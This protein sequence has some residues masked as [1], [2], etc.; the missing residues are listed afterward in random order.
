ML[1]KMFFCFVSFSL[2]YA[3]QMMD[4]KNQCAIVIAFD[5]NA[6]PNLVCDFAFSA[7]GRRS[8][9]N[10]FLNASG[11]VHPEAAGIGINALA[12]M[13]QQFFPFCQPEGAGPAA[14]MAKCDNADDAVNAAISW[15]VSICAVVDVVFWGN[16]GVILG[17]IHGFTA[18]I[19]IV[20]DADAAEP[21]APV[22][23]KDGNVVRVGPNGTALDENEGVRIA[24]AVLHADDTKA[25]VRHGVGLA[26]GP[27]GSD[28]TFVG[29]K[30]RQRQHNDVGT[31]AVN[32]NGFKLLSNWFG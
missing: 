20:Q 3:V 4:S 24:S 32:D 28:S 18:M 31:R 9:G 21:V 11:E 1:I 26:L 27:G 10:N 22:G 23:F 29:N 17:D 25:F 13:R 14:V 16:G 5:G 15:I 7:C 19:M 12:H 2:F 6:R 8:G 30:V